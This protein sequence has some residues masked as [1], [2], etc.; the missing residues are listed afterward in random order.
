[1][2]YE[3]YLEFLDM[4]LRRRTKDGKASILQKNLFVVLS[5]SEMIALTRL[6]SI[7]HLSI[8]MPFRWLAGKT[9]ELAHHNWSPLSMSRVLDTLDEKLATIK[10]N[11]KLILNQRFMMDI[12]KEYREELPEFKEYWEDTFKKRQMSVCRLLLANRERK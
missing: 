7:L 4:M 2:N 12:F 9:H 10:A 6:L 11:P 5:S 1:M 3:Y 8:V